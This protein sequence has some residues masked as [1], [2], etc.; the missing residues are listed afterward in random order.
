MAHG[1]GEFELLDAGDGIGAADQ[2]CVDF[3]KGG[4][5]V[6]I[7]RSV[8]V[9]VRYQ[10]REVLAAVRA[11]DGGLDAGSAGAPERAVQLEI[12]FLQGGEIA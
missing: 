8:N 12:A 9:A 6:A 10:R 11:A 5:D 7:G 3:R 4:V 1:R 2:G